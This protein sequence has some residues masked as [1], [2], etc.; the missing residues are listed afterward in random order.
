MRGRGRAP[1]GPRGPAGNAGLR[2]HPGPGQDAPP[3][4]SLPSRLTPHPG[5][6]PSQPLTAARRWTHALGPGQDA[7][8]PVAE[9]RAP[10]RPR[11][12]GLGPP[13]RSETA[14]GHLSPGSPGPPV[15]RASGHPGLRS[16]GPPVI[17]ASGHP[18]L[19]SPGPPVTRTSGH[20]GLR[21][22][23]PPVTRTSDAVATAH[24][25]PSR[26]ARAPTARSSSPG[27]PP[28]ATTGCAQALRR[29]VCELAASDCGQRLWTTQG[30]V[31]RLFEQFSTGSPTP[32]ET[33][34]AQ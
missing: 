15:T 29:A 34:E 7:L 21:S 14:S 20:P 4:G 31:T 25:G 1:G 2:G 6:T 9:W 16:P 5:R 28:D 24:D 8:G 33:G 11:R 23:G 32:V 19:R 27:D 13:S 12:S 30:G 10:V 18:G 17:R 22:P 26:P 3:P